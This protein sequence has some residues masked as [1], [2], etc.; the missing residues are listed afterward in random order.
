MYASLQKGGHLGAVGMGDKDPFVGSVGTPTLPTTVTDWIIPS[1]QRRSD[2]GCGG[3]KF[4]KGLEGSL[5]G[6]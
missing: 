1:R 3:N 4:R 2:H 6:G 5:E